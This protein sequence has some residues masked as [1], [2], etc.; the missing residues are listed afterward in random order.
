[1]K[2]KNIIITL[3]VLIVIC[4]E[5]K[6]FAKGEAGFT[7]DKTDIMPNDEFTVS[8]DIN[9][10]KVAAYTVWIYFDE[11]KLE[12]IEK[13]DSI[14]IAGN[15]IIYTWVS[16]TGEDKTLSKILDLKFKAKQDGN[17]LFSLIGEFYDENGDRIN[18][19]Y[20]QLEI[21]IG[22]NKEEE[23]DE[24]IEKDI[25]TTEKNNANLEIMRLNQEN[26]EPEFSSDIFQYYLVVDEKIKNIDVT[27]IPE[28]ENSNV[29]ITGN[30]NLKNG[31]NIIKIL[32]TSEDKSNTNEYTINVTRTNNI[33]ETNTDLETL[34]VEE[35]I[36][37]PEYQSNIMNYKIDIS[38]DTN[39]IN[40]LAVPSDNEASV[41]II[42]N[43]NLKTGDN[44]VK[45]N[46]TAKDGITTK[47]YVINVHRRNNEEEIEKQKEEQEIIE[48]AN[49]VLANIE[50]DK[51][52]ENI[53]N[54]TN[55]EEI[56]QD[57]SSIVSI[58][59]IVVSILVVG[60]TV[61]RIVKRRKVM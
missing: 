6:S 53:E 30:Q 42:G 21:N 12:C 34:A 55:K 29:K 13:K 48:N 10:T 56:E 46:V 18:M 52:E 17:A 1:M 27:A 20:N 59:G 57:K 19:E 51:E 50:Q 43:D 44:K 40:I 35:N 16:E 25:K 15:K 32:V 47:Q 61:I 4:L 26:I 22:G 7:V 45:I 2:K 5:S 23:Q 9:D 14:N 28:N 11:Q 38:K 58:I 36:L 33:N 49:N 8:L 39:K 60:I 37:E 41:E 3:L 24:K 31:L 54:S